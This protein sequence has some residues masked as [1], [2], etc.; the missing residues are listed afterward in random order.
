MIYRPGYLGVFRVFRIRRR[1]QL[2]CLSGLQDGRGFIQC[3]ALYLVD[4]GIDMNSICLGS[5]SDIQRAAGDAFVLEGILRLT[6][7][8]RHSALE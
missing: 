6:L 4:D 1:F 2:Q 7:S 8:G 3:D 5:G